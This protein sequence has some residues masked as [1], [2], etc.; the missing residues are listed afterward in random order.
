[1]IA[2]VFT[3]PNCP[4]CVR[5]KALLEQRGVEYEEVP[6]FVED[7]EQTERN[8]QS[9]IETVTAVTGTAPRTMPQIFLGATYI[10]GFT[11]LVKHYEN[12][13]AAAE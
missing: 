12:V 9:L 6:V 7:A 2:T 1:M 10:G 5:A 3:K 4:Y 13:D 11:D 8:R